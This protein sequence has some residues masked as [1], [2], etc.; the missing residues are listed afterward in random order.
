MIQKL[1][2][3]GICFG[4]LLAFATARAAEAKVDV[5]IKDVKKQS[6]LVIKQKVKMAEIS[7]ELG[8]LLPKIHAYLGSKNITP[9]SAPMTH[10]KKTA[11]DA[12]EIEAGFVVPEGTKGEGEIVSSE[13]PAGKAAFTVHVGPYDALPKTYEAMEAVLKTKGLQG[14][15]SSWEFYVTDPG[16]TKPEELKTE[17]YMPVEAI[18]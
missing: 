15:G 9:L 11:A 8:K 10:F 2:L 7:A 17:I 16:S 1:T 3:I 5:E 18:K 12:F 14:K 6:T 4:A 13:L